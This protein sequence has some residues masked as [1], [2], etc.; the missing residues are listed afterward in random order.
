MKKL[1]SVSLILLAL[2]SMA[3]ADDAKVMPMMVGRI[4]FAPTFAFAVGAYDEDGSYKSLGDGEGSLK[5]LNLGFALEYGVIDWITAALQWAPGWTVW[6]DVDKKVPFGLNATGQQAFSDSSVNGNGPADI[7]LG[8]KIQIIGEKAPVKS[9]MFRF[10]VGPGVK[11]PLPATDMKEQLEN[12]ADGDAVTAANG[13]YHVLGTGLRVYFDYI[14]NEHF[15]INLYNETL[16]YPIKGDLRNAN[17][18]EY[19]PI[20]IAGQGARLKAQMGGTPIPATLNIEPEVE[21]NYG[22]DLTFEAEGVYTTSIAQGISLTAGLPVNYKFTPGHKYSVDWDITGTALDASLKTAYEPYLEDQDPTHLLTV[23]PNVSVFITKTPMPLEFK[24][25]YTAPV[26]G[27]NIEQAK[28]S[29]SLQAR[30]Y[31]ALPGR[32]Q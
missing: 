29:V 12:A 28:H 19:A 3:F 6:S 30:L 14:I 20:V 26:W 24:L 15:F 31:F 13:D 27:K 5:A 1:L 11:I 7:F 17:Y 22:Y 25:T 23:K 2:G 21:V 9:T 16:F 10:A 4:Y 18:A 32:P 8:A